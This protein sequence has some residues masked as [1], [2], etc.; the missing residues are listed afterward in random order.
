MATLTIGGRSFEIAP[1]KL[2]ALRQAAPHIDAIN[3][4]ASIE[5]IEGLME[6]AEHIVAILGIGLR[7]IDASLTPEALDDLI[8]ADDMHCATCSPNPDLPQRGKRR[9]LPNRPRRREPKRAT[10]RP[11]LLA[12]LGGHRGRF[13]GSD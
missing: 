9:L 3:A 4:A 12:D 2:G 13:V 7:K 11:R 8:G 6:N 1:Y 5:T 10:D